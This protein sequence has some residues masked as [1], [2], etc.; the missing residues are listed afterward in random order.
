VGRP[1]PQPK[2]NGDDKVVEEPLFGPVKG[3]PH[4]QPKGNGDL[5][6]C[7]H[8]LRARPRGRPHPQPKGNGDVTTTSTGATHSQSWGGR[9]PSRKAMETNL[10]NAVLVLLFISGRP[11]PQPKGNGDG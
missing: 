2:G 11:H 5:V 3:R 9:T 4:P 7:F 10:S 6:Q 8:K 1:H